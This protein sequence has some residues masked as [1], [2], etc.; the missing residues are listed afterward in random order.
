MT[1]NNPKISFIIPAYNCADTIIES[2]ESVFNGNFEVGDEV[3]IVNDAPT[4]KTWQIINDLQK[5]YPV[6]EAISH[7]INKGSATAG[8]NTGIDCSKNNLIFCL[9]SDNVLAPNTVPA[10]KNTC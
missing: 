8:R 7:N 3:I 2:I 9:D 6:I 4:D 1:Y 5:K 10:L